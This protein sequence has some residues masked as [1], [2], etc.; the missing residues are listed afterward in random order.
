MKGSAFTIEGSTNV[1]SFQCYLT[2]TNFADTI[3]IERTWRHRT[4]TFDRLTLKYPVNE[5]DC[6]IELMTEDL[7]SLLQSDRFP[8]LFLRVKTIEVIDGPQEI[9]N[10]NVSSEVNVTIAGVTREVRVDKGSVVNHSES[11]LTFQGKVSLDMVDF[12]I[13]PPVKFFGMVKVDNLLE[14]SFSITMEV[15]DLK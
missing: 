7:R 4:I 5:F 15:T 1:S 3:A 8:Y 13:E 2:K 11:L 6:Q 12:G 10:L 14:V 9:E